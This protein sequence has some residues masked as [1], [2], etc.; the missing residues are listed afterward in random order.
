MEG[1]RREIQESLNIYRSLAQKDPDSY[2]PYVAATLNDLGIL[3]SDQNRTEEARREYEES[4]NIYRNLAQK[5]PES[6]LPKVGATLNNL[7]ILD[8]DKNR[9]E[10]SRKIYAKMTKKCPSTY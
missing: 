4:L 8:I 3:D 6:Y 7:G 5:D 2:L 10:G 1:A 9:V